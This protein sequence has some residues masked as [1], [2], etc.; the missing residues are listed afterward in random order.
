MNR[1]LQNA[2][3]SI[4]ADALLKE[5]TYFNVQDRLQQK[6]YRRWPIPAL[7]LTCVFFCILFG[8]HHFYYESS[9]L[10]SID[11]NPSIELS[12][13]PFGKVIGEKAYNEDGEN[14]IATLDLKHKPYEEALS[15]LLSSDA[16][17]PYLNPDAF[18]MVTLETDRPAE[19]QRLL[20]SIQTCVDQALASHHSDVT[21]DYSCTGS[22][23][24]EEAHEH[25]MSAGKYQALQELLEADPNATLEEFQDKSM[26]EIKTHADHCS[27][28]SNDPNES[29]SSCEASKQ[30]H[31]KHH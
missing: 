13:N 16:L 24:T 27:S 26:K 10:I 31:D 15:E 21:T 4:Q 11:I 9:R 1:D 19:D 8:A 12:L 5:R 7:A 22:H 17:K 29:D 20:E 18:L 28:L 30:H 14:V 23:S 25:G 3:D 2:F 6:P